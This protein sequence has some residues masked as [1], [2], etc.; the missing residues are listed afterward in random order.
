LDERERIRRPPAQRIHPVRNMSALPQ[1]GPI[2]D[3]LAAAPQPAAETPLPQEPEAA[4]TPVPPE[5]EA[6]ATGAS[7][8]PNAVHLGYQVIEEYLRQGQR[9]AAQMAAGLGGAGAGPGAAGDNSFQGLSGRLLRDGFVWLE[10]LAKIWATFDPPG[11]APAGQPAAAPGVTAPGGADPIGFQVR[12]ASSEPAEVT[13]ALR[14]SAGDRA[15][16][17]H[18]LRCPDPQAPPIGGV[19][20]SR[21]EDSGC[22]QVAVRVPE[23]QLPG[24]YSGVVYDR[25]D[26]AVQGTLSVR[27]A[28]GEPAP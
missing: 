1:Q 18:D 25:Q 15:L 3:P 9:V 19:E 5:P 21:S 17:V 26:G 22:W 6:A 7:G 20:L 2:P 27:V 12:I 16:A 14:P 28:P 4:E 13:I 8:V 24:L 11:G 10:H 23:Q